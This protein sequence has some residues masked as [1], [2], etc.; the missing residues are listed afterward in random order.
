MTINTHKLL[1]TV[2]DL[3]VVI[4]SAFLSYFFVSY[5]SV[6]ANTY[7]LLYCI[8][9]VSLATIL[10]LLF[11]DN[12]YKYQ[13][14]LNPAK[15][16]IGL[17]KFLF[18]SLFAL[19]L[20]AFILKLSI[21]TSNRVLIGKIF[22]ILF[23]IF[24]ISRVYLVPLFYYWLVKNKYVSRNLIIIG[25]GTLSIEKVKFL[26]KNRQSYYNIIGFLDNDESVQGKIIEGYPVLG[27][28]KDLS[29]IANEH[30]VKD[31][32]ISLENMSNWKLQ[33]IIN[34]CKR[35]GKTIHVISELYDIVT[36]KMEIDEIGGIS[37]FRVKQTNYTVYETLKRIYDIF[38]S[39]LV[40]ILLSPF[41]ILII[42]LIMVTSKGPIFYNA[43]VIGKRQ[44]EFTMYKFR[45][46]YYQS[47]TK[48]HENSVT[49]MIVNNKTTEKLKKDNRITPIGKILRKLSI[50]EFP[51]FFNVLKGEMSIVGPRPCLPYE[52]EV[53]D[54]WHRTRFV[55]NPGI[56]GLWQIKG[57]NEVRFNDQIALDLY[58]IEHRSIRLDF[59]IL[60][61]TIPVIVFGK[62]GL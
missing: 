29:S 47:S 44:K 56:T 36:E 5:F 31:I 17:L 39:L 7:H 55:I 20:A 38:L 51:Q 2:H 28:T 59:E 57:R 60:L 30:Q 24:F 25:T 48:V 13:F 40:I 9:G 54:K 50:D 16:T 52:H 26:N 41:G 53:M 23:M 43:R 12:F 22:I 1:L 42:L 21:I 10:I 11:H 18:A 58:Y 49:E 8:T 4:T 27:H 35:S 61:K 37:S 19:I 46:M 14:V 34:F 45:S 33:S 6:S 15:H 62:G 3:I 32:L